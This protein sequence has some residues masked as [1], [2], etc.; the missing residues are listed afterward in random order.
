MRGP[1]YWSNYRKNIIVVKLDLEELEREPTHRIDGFADRLK[2]LM[3]SLKD[4]H[5][6]EGHKGGFFERVEQGTWMGHVIEHIAI[7]IQTL[8]GMF[9]GYG[10]TRSAHKQGVYFVVFAYEIEEVGRYAIEAAVRI[11]EALVQGKEYDLQKDLRQLEKLSRRYRLGPSTQSIVDEAEKKCIPFKRLDNN[12]LVVFGHGVKQQKLRGSLAGTTRGMGLRLARDKESTRQ[13]LAR[14][15]IP[16]P[17]GILVYNEQDVEELISDLEFPIVIKPIEGSSGTGVTR[18]VSSLREALMA[19]KIAAS[20]STPVIMEEFVKGNDYRLILVNYKLIA[21]SQRTAASVTGDGT[22]TIEELVNRANTDPVRVKGHVLTK[23]EIEEETNEILSAKGLRLSS[24]PANG[25]TIELK[26][27]PNISTGGGSE[28]VTDH[29]H[30]YNIFLAERAAK[31][32]GLDICGIDII[33]RDLGKPLTGGNGCIIEVNSGPG[34]RMH[35]FPAKG[36]PRNIAKPIIEML[37]PDGDDGRIP[38]VAITGTNG[39]TTTTRMIAH[40]AQ[41]AGRYHNVGYTTSDGIYINGNTVYEGDC[42]GPVS[43]ESILFDPTVDFAVLECARGGIL[44]AGLAFDQSDIS[45][46]TNITEDHLGTK[47]IHTLDEMARV[48]SVVPRT[49]KKDGYAILNAEDDLVYDMREDVDCR[50]ALFSMNDN[51]ERIKRHCRREGIAAVVENGYL[52]ICDGRWKTRIER[53]VDIPATLQG[54]AESMIKNLLPAVLTAYLMKFDVNKIRKALQ[55]F[56]PSA[57]TTPGRMNIFSFKKFELMIDYAHNPDGFR[58]LKKFMDKTSASL[59]IGII[60]VAGDRRDEDIREVGKLAA[61][62]FDEVVIRH[63]ED[64][65]GRDIE[66]MNDLLMQGIH[67]IN[68]SLPV[69]IIN[70]EADALKYAMD[71]APKDAFIVLC[72]DKIQAMIDY[73]RTAEAAEKKQS[74]RKVGKVLK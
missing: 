17:K 35:H 71:T 33:A 73:V 21:A 59:K 19:F 25:E 12:S 40:L 22:S 5:C 53:I 14:E 32:I 49:T 56:I 11:A 8:A 48:K 2:A 52:T 37:F 42:T 51:N 50:I 9:C 66:D 65:R 15:F 18:P 28:D 46:V 6:S 36:L 7:E 57:E 38:L 29:V 43:A 4:H 68:P 13:L 55:T 34:L 16:V 47:E 67:E 20:V 45:V 60:A 69:K 74:I 1:N 44:R 54:R 27:T 70:N 23:I 62:T 63:D 26:Y 10:R 24:V 58:E 72:A 64:L 30:P 31:I 39:K 41:C 3:P 61:S